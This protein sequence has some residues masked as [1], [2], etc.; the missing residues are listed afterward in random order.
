MVDDKKDRKKIFAYIE[1]KYPLMPAHLKDRIILYY[2][3]YH[4]LSVQNILP[5]KNG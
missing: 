1:K 4:Y 2:E 5:V 3:I